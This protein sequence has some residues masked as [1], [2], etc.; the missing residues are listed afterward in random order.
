MALGAFL[1]GVLLAET[2]FRHELEANIEPFKG[3]LLGL[4]FIAVGMSIDF[5][6]AAER[7]IDILALA[8]GLTALKFAI[9]FGLGKATGQTTD[10]ARHLAIALSQGGEFAF[11]VFAIAVKDGVIA[12]EL[13]SLLVSGVI[14]SMVLTPL[15]FLCEDKLLHKPKERVNPEEF[16]V[17]EDENQVIIAGFGRVGQIVARI[18]SAKRIGFTALEISQQQ[19]DFVKKYGNKIYYGD[20]SRL[21]LLHAA[22]A[23]TAVIFVLTVDD[24][25]ASLQTCRTV[26][27]HFPHLKIFA[28]ATDRGTRPR[29]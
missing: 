24:E 12:P 1:A 25:K 8:F 2:E 7:P 17:P 26:R 11:V 9:L 19:I 18:L 5:G 28:R 3:L 6:L 15:L 14:L 13:S 23:D 27:K 29:S 10:N 16:E 4:F 21:E 22:R 20:P